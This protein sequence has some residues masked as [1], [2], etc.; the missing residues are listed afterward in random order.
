MVTYSPT[1]K[2]RL[3]ETG[4]KESALAEQFPDTDS[5]DRAFQNL[6]KS[7]VEMQRARLEQ[8]FA[9]VRRSRILELEEKLS[10]SLRAAGFV[11]VSTPLII[12]RKKLEK[13]GVF[14]GGIMEKQVFW[15]DRGHCL[16]PMLAPNLYEYMIEFGRLR[17]RP[18]R[19]FEIGPCFRRE[20]DGQR[21]ANEFT[22]L[23][24]VEM[25]LS[26]SPM[27]R[28]RELGA[29]ILE[30]AGIKGWKQQAEESAVYGDTMDFLDNNG[31]ELASCAIGPHPLDSAWGITDNWVGLGF[32]L[33]RLVMSAGNDNSLAMVGPS[34]AYIDGIRLHL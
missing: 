23:N 1:Q 32:G 2:R 24:V 7:L 10:A 9:S 33:E 18:I 19:F 34:L 22:M 12:T 28:L 25:G 16:R 4:A 13:M 30:I 20:T 26:D 11:Q 8:F 17:P 14:E 15:L 5:R 27:E 21:H 3:A 31:M 29:M 6:E